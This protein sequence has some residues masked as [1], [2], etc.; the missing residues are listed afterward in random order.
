M[1]PHLAGIAEQLP[2]QEK[3]CQRNARLPAFSLAGLFPVRKEH[4][5]PSEDSILYPAM[6]LP[7]FFRNFAGIGTSSFHMM[8]IGRVPSCSTY[9]AVPR[10]V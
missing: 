5:M 8:L 6:S 4:D 2:L 1:T 9:R 10:Q 3:P 7:V